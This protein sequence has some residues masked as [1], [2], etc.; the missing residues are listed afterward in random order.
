MQLKKTK[1]GVEIETN[2]TKGGA[3]NQKKQKVALKIKKKQKAALKI[4]KKTK[5][6]VE[7]QKKQKAALKIKKN[8]RRR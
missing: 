8:E 6:G 5:G 7:N 2:Q 1:G 3:G 4:K